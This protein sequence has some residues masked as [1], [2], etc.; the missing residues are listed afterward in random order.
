MTT[1]SVSAAASERRLPGRKRAALPRE[2]KAGA[3]LRRLRSERQRGD[4]A[5]A[6]GDATRG[7]DGNRDSVDDLRHERQG[8]DERGLVVRAEPERRAVPARLGS[9]RDDDVDPRG[10]DRASPPRPSSPSSRPRRRSRRAPRTSGDGSPRAAPRMRM[11]FIDAHL[12]LSPVSCGAGT[13]GSGVPGRQAELIPEAIEEALHLGG[14]V[15]AVL[16]SREHEVDPERAVG[17]ARAPPDLIAQRVGRDARPGEHREAARP[18][19]RR[20]RAPASTGLRP[21]APARSGARR[22]AARRAACASGWGSS[23]CP[24]PAVPRSRQLLAHELADDRAVGATRDLRHDVGHHPAEVA[25]RRRTGLGDRVVD[26]AARAPSSD[27]GSG[28]SASS[29]VEL[30]LLP[31]GLL[32]PARVAE[33]LAPTPRGA[34]AR[35]GAPAAPRPP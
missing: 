5:A 9:L 3:D 14:V 32:V 25:Q 34:C 28:R 33:R 16:D 19:R 4:D 1:V 2:Q 20:P 30:G 10:L 29:T 23:S 27:S 18:R 15:I 8:S 13:G 17:A 12:D 7:D 31:V 22:R 21:S 6:V 24:P 35:A 11:R 26:D